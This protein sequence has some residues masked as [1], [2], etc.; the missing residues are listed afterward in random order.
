[1]NSFSTKFTTYTISSIK[2]LFFTN[3]SNA[4]SGFMSDSLNPELYT[5]IY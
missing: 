1:M 3:L 2:A 4:D 5:L